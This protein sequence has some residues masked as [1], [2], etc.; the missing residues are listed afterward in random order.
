[1]GA[2]GQSCPGR[3]ACFGHGALPGRSAFGKEDRVMAT[4]NQSKVTVVDLAKQLIAGTTKHLG[5]GTKV[6]LSGGSFTAVEITSKL[7][8]LVT[9]RTDVDT[10]K[11]Q[12]KA[13]LAAEKADMPALRNL[14][15][16]LVTFVKAAYGNAPDVLADFWIHPKAR[17]PLTVEAKVAAAAKR[18]ATRA[19][20]KTMGSKQKKGVKGDVTGITVTPITATKPIVVTPASPTAGATSSGTTAAPTP[21]AT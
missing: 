5:N 19:A 3:P 12:T 9:L 4:K 10:A 21:H 15:G 7:N 13:K 18:K 17:T 8:Q 16:A 2:A 6:M 14:M 1:M 20:R 11:A